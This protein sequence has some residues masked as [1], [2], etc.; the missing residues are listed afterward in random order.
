MKKMCFAIPLMA[1]VLQGCAKQPTN[2]WLVGGWTIAEESCDSDGGY[3]FERTGQ[4]RSWGMEGTWA[5]KHSDLTL[6]TTGEYGDDYVLKP[7]HEVTTL[8]ITKFDTNSFETASLDPKDPSPQKWKRCSY[9]LDKTPPPMEGQPTQPAE[10][11]PTEPAKSSGGGLFGPSEQKIIW[12]FTG[13]FTYQY[14]SAIIQQQC[15]KQDEKL[16]SYTSNGWRIVSSSPATRNVNYGVCQGRD[17][18]IEK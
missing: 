3:V 13:G 16:D 5:L 10:P 18:I 15:M 12:Q 6:T 1:L 4:L 8:H 11:T 17:V 2:D 7:V 14:N 9:D